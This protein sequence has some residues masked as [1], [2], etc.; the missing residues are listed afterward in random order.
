MGIRRSWILGSVMSLAMLPVML[1]GGPASAAATPL[2]LNEGWA[3]SWSFNPYAANFTNFSTLTNLQLAYQLRPKGNYEP[4]IATSWKVS[5]N[6]ITLSLR[7]NAKWQNGQPVTSKDVL[8]TFELYG[9]LGS[10]LGAT[11]GIV[12]M[13]APNP[14]TVTLTLAKGA[15][16]AQILQTVLGESLVPS[17]IY[18]RFVKPGL[19]QKDLVANSGNSGKAVKAAEAFTGKVSA[20]LI[21]YQPKTYIGDG[22]YQIT[23]MTTNE[24][25]LKENPYFYGKGPLHVKNIVIWQDSSNS[26][27]WAEM[28]AG[29]TDFAWTG[30]PETVMKKWE[31]TPGNKV[32]LTWDWSTYDWYFNDKRYPLSNPKVRQA[33]AYVFNRPKLTEIANGFMRNLPT[34][35]PTGLQHVIGHKWLTPAEFR[36]LNPYNYNPAKAARILKSLHF[37]KTGSGWVMPN[38]KPFTLSIIAPSGYSGPTVSAEEAASELT[39]F[40]IKTQASAIEQPGYWTQQDKG[41]FDISWGW[42]GWWVLNPLQTMY[43]NLVQQNYTPHESGYTGLGFGPMVNVPGLG[44]V[45]ITKTLTTQLHDYRTHAQIAKATWDWVRLVNQQLPFLEYNSKR[46]QVEYSTL[47]YNDWPSQKST[48]WDQIGGNA[49]G[50]LA[51]MLLHGYVRP[52]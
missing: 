48:L 39:Q 40:G 12:G 14:H 21:K 33:L 17:S 16:P 31:S 10:V 34:K 23:N 32:E 28:A 35:V 29:K 46:I 52:R 30:A 47:R 26:Q 4:L 25:I 22:P 15:N 42:G 37:K 9:S 11:N 7:S 36:S 27:G 51:L 45:N 38:G 20:A 49:N 50:A 3:A 8:D 13:S 6:T 24:A 18:G 1:P 2:Q 44:R 41:Q 43:D 19:L 5:G